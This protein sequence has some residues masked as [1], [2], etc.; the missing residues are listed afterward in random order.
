LWGIRW[1]TNT[2]FMDAASSVS[3][4]PHPV[5]G[6]ARLVAFAWTNVRCKDRKAGS[7]TRGR[8][9]FDAVPQELDCLAHKE[10]TDPEAIALQGIKADESVKDRR[11]LL[12][13]NADPGIVHVDSDIR[14]AAPAAE[15]NTTSRFGVLDRI[16]D[17]IAQDGSKQEVVAQ[18][19][20][21]RCHRTNNYAVICRHIFVIAPRAPEQ[22]IN[23]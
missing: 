5:A 13:R 8:A 17:Q 2:N 7:S 1:F 4:L 19:Q 12:L 6:Y 10:K 21:I 23:A 20:R 14:A 3:R 15:Q 18:Y 9:E 11:R 16:A 22:L